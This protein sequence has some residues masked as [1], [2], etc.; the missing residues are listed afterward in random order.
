MIHLHRLLLSILLTLAIVPSAVLGAV[1]GIDFGQSTT[2]AALVSPG[3][4]F[5][6]VLTQDSKRKDVSGLAFKGDER[7]YGGNAATIV[8]CVML[9]LYM[10]VF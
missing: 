8:S 4:P 10:F 2:K 6:I 3:V 9:V 5:E 7:L 1:L